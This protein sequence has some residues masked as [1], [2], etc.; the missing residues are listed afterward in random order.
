MAVKSGTASQ[1]STF[2]KQLALFS[3]VCYLKAVPIA[4]LSKTYLVSNTDFDV[5]YLLIGVSISYYLSLDSKISLQKCFGLL[6]DF[7]C[8]A[9]RANHFT[10]FEGP[11]RS[12]MIVRHN[13]RPTHEA[14][15]VQPSFDRRPYI[16]YNQ[17]D[18]EP[19]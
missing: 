9:V 6:A 18:Q 3:T 16:D 14:D 19:Y 1:N 7:D 8:Y 15:T 4:L 11:I 13:C 17:I 2:T 12:L 10:F 5:G